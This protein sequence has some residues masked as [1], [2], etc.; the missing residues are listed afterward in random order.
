MSTLGQ[1][2]AAEDPE[3]PDEALAAMRHTHGPKQGQLVFT[4]PTMVALLLFFV[5]ALQCMSTVGAL[6]RETN[7]WP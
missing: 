7:S 4:T 5:Y 2:A 1:I 6:R 3:A